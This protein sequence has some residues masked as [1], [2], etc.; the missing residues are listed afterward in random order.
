MVE[1]MKALAR[2]H[3]FRSL[4]ACVRPTLKERYPTIP[5]ERYA[6]WTRDDGLP[7]DPWLRLHVRL[8]GRIVRPSPMSMTMRGTVS[9]W[10][11]WTGMAF[12]ETGSY[13]VPGAAAPVQIDREIDEGIYC[14]PNVWVVHDLQSPR[15]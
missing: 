6:R 2:V 8:G 1:A 12:P 15:R 5:I 9:D 11:R 4:V 3:G 14:D 7:F 10:E 13:V